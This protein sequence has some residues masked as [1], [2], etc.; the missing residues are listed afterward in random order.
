MAKSFTKRGRTNQNVR[1]YQRLDK[2]I[3]EVAKGTTATVGEKK[4]GYMQNPDLTLSR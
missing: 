2:Q 3:R 1:V 4:Y